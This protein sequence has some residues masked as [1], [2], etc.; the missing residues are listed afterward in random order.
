MAKRDEVPLYQSM[1]GNALA[2][3]AAGLSVSLALAGPLMRDGLS[4]VLDPESPVRKASR[5]VVRELNATVV[6][7]SSPAFRSAMQMKDALRRRGVAMLPTDAGE[8]LEAW[9]RE[10]IEAEK[11]LFFSARGAYQDLKPQADEV[12]KRALGHALAGLEGLESAAERGLAATMNRG[13][14]MRQ[15]KRAAPARRAPKAAAKKTKRRS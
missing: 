3:G 14:D 2:T 6:E 9:R 8:L 1:L 13:A 12:Q 4:S 7:G 15:G 11:A 5:A 10:F